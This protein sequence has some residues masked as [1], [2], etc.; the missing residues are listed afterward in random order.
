M[1]L[2]HKVWRIA[3]LVV[4]LAPSGKRRRPGRKRSAEINWDPWLDKEWPGTNHRS[5]PSGPFRLVR[6]SFPEGDWIFFAGTGWTSWRIDCG[7]TSW[8]AKRC[9][10]RRTRARRPASSWSGGWRRWTP[11]TGAWNGAAPRP[12]RALARPPTTCGCSSCPT[13]GSAT[14]CSWSSTTR[15]S[16]SKSWNK[17]CSASVRTVSS[18]AGNV[19]VANDL[20]PG[21]TQKVTNSVRLMVSFCRLWNEDRRRKRLVQVAGAEEVA[22]TARPA[23]EPARGA[24]GGRNPSPAGPEPSIGRRRQPMAGWGEE[25]TLLQLV[26]YEDESGRYLLRF[27]F[28]KVHQMSKKDSSMKSFLLFDSLVDWHCS[29][30]NRVANGVPFLELTRIAFSFVLVVGRRNGATNWWRDWATGRRKRWRCSAKW[31]RKCASCARSC[32]SETSS[33]PTAR[34]ASRNSNASATNWP[35]VSGNGSQSGSRKWNWS[36]DQIRVFFVASI[37]NVNYC[38]TEVQKRFWNMLRMSSEEPISV[39]KWSFLVK[40]I[41]GNRFGDDAARPDGTGGRAAHSGPQPVIDPKIS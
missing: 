7:T 32:T 34:D 27:I 37:R 15:P 38:Q 40:Q 22:S 16:T 21:Y 12:R 8:G 6:P 28:H 23:P 26:N 3:M 4:L 41:H 24:T 11:L 36:R 30:Q 2:P 31:R 35:P 19:F 29:P 13:S 1:E 33:W 39:S 5:W 9:A 20:C 25:F 18:P 14:S 17:P 10:W